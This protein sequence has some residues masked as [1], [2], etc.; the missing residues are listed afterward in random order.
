M[1]DLFAASGAVQAVA[2]LWLPDRPK[3]LRTDGTLARWP[4]R[5][6]FGRSASWQGRSQICQTRM[7]GE[8][9]LRR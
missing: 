3:Q 1:A 9:D 4:A 5:L 2:L 7:L 6:L 8:Y